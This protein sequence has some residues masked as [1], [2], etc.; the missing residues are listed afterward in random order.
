MQNRELHKPIKVNQDKDS[1]YLGLDE[2]RYMLNT[3]RNIGGGARSNFGKT[4][5]LP[6]NELLCETVLDSD[7]FGV[8]TSYAIGTYKSVL[9]NESYVFYYNPNGDDYIARVNADKTCQIVYQGACLNFS[10]EPQHAIKDWRVYLKYDK[11]CAHQGGKQLIWTDGLN[12]IG[13][14]DVEASIDT[15]SFNTPFFDVCPDTCAYTQM[16]VP[17]PCGALEGEFLPLASGEADLKNELLDTGFQFRFRHVYYDQRASEWTDVSTLYFQNAKGCFDEVTEGLPR[18][19]MFRIP[20]GN[21]LVER[22]DVAFRKNNQ[23]Q[24]FLAETIEKYASYTS[25]SQ[26]WHERELAPL[27]DFYEP[28]CDFAYIF[29]NDKGCLPIEVKQTDRVFNPTPKK[30]QGLIP[31]NNGLGFYNY[32]K[33]NCPL[34]LS[35]TEKIEVSLN[36]QNENICQEEFVTVVAKVLIYNQEDKTNQFIYRQGGAPYIDADDVTDTAY[37]GGNKHGSF[38]AQITPFFDQFFR[39]DTRNFIMYIEGTDIAQEMEQWVADPNFTNPRFQGVVSGIKIPDYQIGTGAFFFQRVEI[40]VKKGT[41]GFLRLVSHNQTSGLGDNQDTSTY[42]AGTIPNLNTY[43]WW[44]NISGIMTYNKHEIYFDT[45]NVVGGKLAIDETFVVHDL[46]K[47]NIQGSKTSSAYSGYVT[48]NGNKPVE[49]A[50]IF[51]DPWYRSVTDHNGF[52]FFYV[53]GNENNETITVSVG[54]EQNCG[55]AFVGTKDVILYGESSSMRKTNIKIEYTDDPY[56]E[57]DFRQIVNVLVTD[58]DNIPVGGIRVAMSGTKYKVTDGTTGKATFYVRNYLTRNRQVLGVVMNY[59]YCI[60]ND[61]LNNCTFCMPK[62]ATTLL[63]NCFEGNTT[64]LTVD[65]DIN[66]DSIFLGKKGLKANGRY[67]WG[68]VVQG[69]CGKIS[70]VYPVTALNGSIGA[71]SFMDIPKTQATGGISFC[72]I[73]YDLNGFAPPYWGECL[74]IVRSHNLNPYALQWVVDDYERT[75]DS[76]IKLTIQSLSDYNELYNFETNVFYDYLKG[77]RVE[78]ISNGGGEIFDIPTYGVLNYQIL[79]P[80]HD[81]IISGDEEGSLPDNYFNQILIH[82]D[83]TLPLDLKGSKIEIQRPQDCV[84]ENMPFFEIAVSLDIVNLAG[85]PTVLSPVGDF[86]TFDTYTVIRQIGDFAPQK[87]EHINPSDFWGDKL[88]GISDIGKVHFRNKYENEKR[89]GRNIT[90]N[91]PNQFNYF[92]DLEKTFDAPEQGDLIAIGIYDGK[93]GVAIGQFDNFLFQLAN[94]FLR[95]GN[96]GIVRAVPADALISDGEPKVKGKFGCGYD[97]IGSVFFGDG[98][99][100]WADVAKGAYVKHDFGEAKDISENKMSTYFRKKWQAMEFFN[101]TAPAGINKYRFSSGF[102]YHTNALYLTMKQLDGSNTMN[103][104]NCLIAPNETIAIDVE[105]ED[106][107]TWVSPTPEEYSGIKISDSKGCAF[108]GFYKN[109]IYIHPVIATEFNRF[110]GVTVDRVVMISANQEPD[111]IKKFVAAE[112]QDEIMW[113]VSDVKV[114]DPNYR[115]EIPPKKIVRSENKWNAA[116]LSNI[117]SRGGLHTSGGNVATQPRGYYCEVTFVRDNTDDLKYGTIDDEKR[118]QFDALD[119]LLV[120]YFYSAQSGL[121]ENL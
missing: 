26:K 14:I 65:G 68:V 110:C 53:V 6:A 92:G 71:D 72:Q 112:I 3:E 35:E 7:S 91:A 64:E 5:P 93:I 116:F 118:I 32:E 66:T 1:K 76:K 88:N 82:D 106:F 74:K 115:S 19:I 119:Y 111:I 105:R 46:I 29:C 62:T 41:R 75:S 34:L 8:V 47:H 60:A 113:F 98:W 102:N 27:D 86:L 21:P 39:E 59:N 85:V 31:L 117:N 23:P 90:V 24:W 67:E 45:C 95:V 25:E 51:Y 52:Y 28:S 30:P 17:E 4:T 114:D 73:H 83:G 89:F 94:D 103:E 15:N 121:R 33:G 79:S 2:A 18:C 54:V 61:C 40:K 69:D 22:I 9:T 99:I 55:G 81:K 43:N 77:D 56:Y 109:K 84:E 57:T 70:A 11:F 16:C 58:C 97:H 12:E 20:V 104:K 63:P 42:V 48:D 13:Q 38:N 107:L 101:Q 36:C 108:L 37:F 96:D 100:S 50:G 120:K 87:F 10:P 80:F 78:F 44:T 49:G